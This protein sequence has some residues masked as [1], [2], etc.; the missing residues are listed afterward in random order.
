MAVIKAMRCASESAV[1]ARRRR[2]TCK[3]LANQIRD[4]IRTRAST[5]LQCFIRRLLAGAETKRRR[6]LK[7]ALGIAAMVRRKKAKRSQRTGHRAEEGEARERATGAHPL[8]VG[9]ARAHKARQVYLV[10]YVQRH[11][12]PVPVFG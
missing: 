1:I 9:L 8:P 4:A 7:K 10:K 6:E 3:E 12:H 5:T 11:A 2:S